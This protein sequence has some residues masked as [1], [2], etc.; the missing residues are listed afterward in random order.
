MEVV[1]SVNF[2]PI[3][4]YP[5]QLGEMIGR[6]S[7]TKELQDYRKFIE[8]NPSHFGKWIPVYEIE[9]SDRL[10][11]VV[12]FLHWMGHKDLLKAGSRSV[13]FKDDLPRISEMMRVMKGVGND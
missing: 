9:G 3:A 8:K 10:Y 13:K 4:A 5:K 1:T 7:L 6:K 2:M 12:C 11:D